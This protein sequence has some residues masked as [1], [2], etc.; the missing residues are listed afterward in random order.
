MMLSIVIAAY[1]EERRIG[2]SLLRIDRFLKEQS[3]DFEII[4]VDDGSTDDTTRIVNSY[5]PD[6]KNLRNIS[7]PVNRGKG[8]A[9]RQGVFLAAGEAI[10]LTDA[11]LSTPIEELSRLEPYV[12]SNQYD[13]VIGSRA[14]ESSRIIKKQP[15]WRQ[16]MGKI[17]NR[18]VRLIVLDSFSDTQCGFKLFSREAAQDLFAKAQVDRFAYDVEILVL[19]RTRGYSVLELPVKWINAPGSKVNPVFDSLQMLFDLVRIRLFAG[20]MAKKTQAK[21]A[22]RYY[23]STK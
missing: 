14:L 15:W 17:F 18:I 5:K 8:Y 3:E 12:S 19:A 20:K 1:N 9:L 21:G 23:I 16:G 2:A 6:M 4:V 22:C 7:Y 11:D 10:L 13:I